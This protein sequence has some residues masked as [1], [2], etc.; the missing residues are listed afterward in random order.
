MKVNMVS[1]LNIDKLYKLCCTKQNTTKN[2]MSLFS[3]RLYEF[4][5]RVE[6]ALELIDVSV[7]E[8]FILK[9]YATSVSPLNN[10][11]FL[12]NDNIPLDAPSE[13]KKY[14]DIITT[15]SEDVGIHDNL[16]YTYPYLY[17]PAYLVHGD[18]VVKFTGRDLFKLFEKNPIDFFLKAT[19]GTCATQNDT[20]QTLVFK[21]D[22]KI[23]IVGIHSFIKTLFLNKFYRYLINNVVPADLVT[24]SELHVNFSNHE[25][26]FNIASLKHPY[27]EVDLK[28]NPDELNTS[29]AIKAKNKV[30]K[31][32]EALY[33]TSIDIEMYTNFSTFLELYMLLPKRMFTVIEDL[34]VPFNFKEIYIP[35]SFEPYYDKLESRYTLLQEYIK[36]IKDNPAAMYQY[37]YLNSKIAFTVSYSFEDVNLYINP[38]IKNKGYIKETSEALNFMMASA[39]TLYNVI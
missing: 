18:M 14:C 38:L 9:D 10:K 34:K 3:D 31:A 26:K 37:T 33:M 2:P 13:V 28:N 7:Y 27:L 35:K 6:I 8:A 1:T 23:D 39:K 20:D 24:D 30:Y 12:F 16:R 19:S 32:D 25:K 11:H 21:T 5:N 15:I 17:G 22:Y 4:Y 36:S 29:A